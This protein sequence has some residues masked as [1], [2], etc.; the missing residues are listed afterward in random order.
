MFAAIR[1]SVVTKEGYGCVMLGG[2]QEVDVQQADLVPA[3][4]PA[5]RLAGW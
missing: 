4:D 3:L 5:W 2:S 1:S